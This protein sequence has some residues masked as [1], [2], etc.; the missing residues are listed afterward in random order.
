MIQIQIPKSK[1]HKTLKNT[2]PNA[3]TQ[4]QP[5]WTQVKKMQKEELE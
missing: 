4:C 5:L 2:T 3:H 1:Q